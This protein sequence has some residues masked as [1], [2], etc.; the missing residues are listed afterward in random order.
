MSQMRFNVL[1][2]DKV[3]ML[4]LFPSFYTLLNRT[5]VSLIYIPSIQGCSYNLLF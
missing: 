5:N 2:N 1:M 3:I 4:N